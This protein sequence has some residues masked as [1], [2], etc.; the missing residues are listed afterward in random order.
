MLGRPLASDSSL[1]DLTALRSAGFVWPLAKG[2]LLLPKSWEHLESGIPGRMQLHPRASSRGDKC[3]TPSDRTHGWAAARR[4]KPTTL[5]GPNQV[6]R[7]KIDPIIHVPTGLGPAAFGHHC[8]DLFPGH[9]WRGLAVRS[10]YRPVATTWVFHGTIIRTPPFRLG[11]PQ[12]GLGLT[13]Y[14]PRAAEL[15]RPI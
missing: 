10:H 7:I 5:W 15:W 12:R 6:N 3:A 1:P 11:G 4:V 14:H 13:V 9:A 2:P 8:S